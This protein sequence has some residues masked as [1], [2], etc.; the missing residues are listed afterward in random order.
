MMGIFKSMNIFIT[1]KCH[2]V[3]KIIY[4]FQIWGCKWY[5]DMKLWVVND[6]DKN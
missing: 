4:I 1:K 2:K 6:I 5:F 3:C